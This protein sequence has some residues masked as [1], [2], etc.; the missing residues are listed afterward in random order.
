MTPRFR[1]ALFFAFALIGC[2]SDTQSSFNS[3]HPDASMGGQNAAS[4]GS[5]NGGGGASGGARA[6]SG[7]A[8]GSG[9]AVGTGGGIGSGGAPPNGAP[10]SPGTVTIEFTVVGPDSYCATAS[11][12]TAG[13]SIDI[14]DASG[15][16]FFS[17]VRN[18]TDVDCTT[19]Q[20]MACP[21]YYCPPPS[22]VAVTGAK[23]IW[24]GSYTTRSTCGAG[25]TCDQTV[26]AAPGTY[27]AKFCAAPGTLTGQSPNQVCTNNGPSK[28]GTVTFEFPSGTVA[29]GTIGP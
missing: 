2:S 3:E 24:D 6:N 21:G 19:C 14:L 28:C 15:H 13:P 4:G 7:G 1:A 17:V 23:M 18:C 27:T 12:C 5:G 26:Y 10:G 20:T 11:L 29:Q 16:S 8:S 9:A 25:F 22:G